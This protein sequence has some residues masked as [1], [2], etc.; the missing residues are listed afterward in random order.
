MSGHP[1]HGHLQPLQDTLKTLSLDLW[2]WGPHNTSHPYDFSPRESWWKCNNICIP[3]S[4]AIDPTA[5]LQCVDEQTVQTYISVCG[6]GEFVFQSYEC[7]CA[8]PPLCSSGRKQEFG[9]C[10]ACTELFS[11]PSPQRSEGKGCKCYDPR[12]QVELQKSPAS[13]ASESLFVAPPC[14]I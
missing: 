14:P 11:D 1:R 13:D 9:G 8:M 12:S 2:A 4:R 7:C 10:H 3:K 6:A 5:V